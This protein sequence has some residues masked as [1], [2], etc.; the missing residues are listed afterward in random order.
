MS[1]KNRREYGTGSISQR[2]DGTWTGRITIGLNEK[3]KPKVKAV[4]GK[5]E[6]EVKSKLKAVRDELARN[7]YV[8]VQKRSVAKFMTDWME[9]KKRN[10]LKDKSYDRLEN[11]VNF[12]IIPKIGHIQ[13]PE[14]T[15]A[16]VQ[17]LLNE[18]R[19]DGYSYSTVKK[20]YDAVNECFRTGLIARQV[21]FNPALGVSVPKK[22]K[23]EDSEI[24]FFT[25]DEVLKLYEAALS[26][27]PNAKKRVYRLGDFVIL[28][29]NTGLRLA[30]LISLKWD[31]VDM[32]NGLL[33]VNS[34]RVTVK[35]RSES[36][37]TKYK[38]IEQKSAKTKNS[39]R[40]IPLNKDALDALSRLKEITGNSKYVLC[41]REGLPIKQRN[42]DRTFRYIEASAGFPEEKIYGIHAMR[43]TFA[44]LLIK[45]KT[46]IKTVSELLGHS[47]I[48][49]TLNTYV[50]VLQEQKADAVSNLIKEPPKILGE[51]K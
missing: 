32:E 21:T 29:L 43:H 15:S 30:E 2:K 24:K 3:G 34:T 22:D 39:I 41:S 49:I 9:S 26:V 20:A 46:D 16:D 47:D 11:T 44:T 23:F 10:E 14:L 50:H 12:Q 42:L 27:F 7:D 17:M 18:L 48:N 5:T 19:D 4:Y 38:V 45:N 28:D 37:E 40:T 36:A 31:D 13:V 35:D 8:N 33:S 51:K 1:D 6:K 25:E